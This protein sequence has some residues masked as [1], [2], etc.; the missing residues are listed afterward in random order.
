[1]AASP[2]YI[3]QK[4]NMPDFTTLLYFIPTAKSKIPDCA[5]VL[6]LLLDIEQWNHGRLQDIMPVGVVLLPRRSGTLS[7]SLCMRQQIRNHYSYRPRIQRAQ[8]LCGLSR[9]HPRYDGGGVNP[10]WRHFHISCRLCHQLQ[11]ELSTLRRLR[12]N[13]IVCSK[14]GSYRGGG[15]HSK[16][17]AELFWPTFWWKGIPGEINDG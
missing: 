3:V 9:T 16:T 1:M 8:H 13:T 10:F 2:L 7:S 15:C 14:H 4:L 12:W 5:I 6:I 11:Q 17:R